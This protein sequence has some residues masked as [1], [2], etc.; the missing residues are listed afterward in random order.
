M[1]LDD[2]AIA[3]ALVFGALGAMIFM[4]MIAEIIEGVIGLVKDV[5][6]VI[7]KK[8]ELR[9]TEY[10]FWFLFPV[11]CMAIFIADELYRREMLR[12][13]KSDEKRDTR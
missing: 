7:T 1:T 2:L 6:A 13:R 9:E 4:T 10:L 11:V 12:V 3:A 8:K 5:I